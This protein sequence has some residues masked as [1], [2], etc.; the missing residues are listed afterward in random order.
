MTEAGFV[1]DGQSDILRNPDDD[2]EKTVFDPELRGK[3]DRFVMRFRK[4]E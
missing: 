2:Y 3:T 1:L 4:P